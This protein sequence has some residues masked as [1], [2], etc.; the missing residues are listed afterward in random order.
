[1]LAEKGLSAFA[2]AVDECRVMMRF[3]REPPTGSKN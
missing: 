3:D 1:M 2:R